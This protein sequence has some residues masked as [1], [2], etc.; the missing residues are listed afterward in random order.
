MNNKS[1][2]IIRRPFTVDKIIVDGN[3]L[4]FRSLFSHEMLSVEINN[5]IIYTG[6]AYGFIKMLLAVKKS[7]KP[8]KFIVTWDGGCDGKKAIYPQYKEGRH[9]QREGMNFDDIIASLK[10][11]RDILGYA[12]I[13]QIRTKGEEADDI[14]STIVKND[15]EHNYIILTNDH[16]LLQLLDLSNVRVLRMTA[17]DTEFWNREKFIKKFG[18]EP[19]FYP[20]FMSVVGDKTDNIPGIKGIG[21][22]T[23]SMIFK[24]LSIPNLINLYA[25]ID[26]I[27]VTDN[28]RNKLKSGKDDAFKFLKII[29]LKKDADIEKSIKSKKDHHK[30]MFVFNELKFNSILRSSKDMLLINDL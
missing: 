12:G 21:E 15:K 11:C 26:L 9:I 5:K 8:K 6:I 18:F 28:V 22:K 16:D 3:A 30:L 14:I 19:K 27:K 2:N 17:K 23:A 24:Q 1:H 10:Y 20:H 25:N 29:E 7:V 13:E 4:A